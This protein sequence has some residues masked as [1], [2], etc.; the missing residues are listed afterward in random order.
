MKSLRHEAPGYE[1]ARDRLA[2]SGDPVAVGALADHVKHL[3]KIV[4][5]RALGEGVAGGQPLA[6]AS[7]GSVTGID[8]KTP[9]KALA[10]GE[11]GL[12]VKTDHLGL[13]AFYE[14]G[15][16]VALPDWAAAHPPS[17][18]RVIRP[19]H[20][21]DETRLSSAL[22][23][24]VEIDTGLRVEQDDQTGHAVL[25]AQGP[26]HFRRALAK[27]DG[28]FGIEVAEGQ[29][30]TAFRETIRGPA[31]CHHRHR[32]QSGGAG[33][34]A[35]VQIEV[36]LFWFRLGELLWA[37]VDRRRDNAHDALV[38]DAGVGQ[39]R[40]ARYDSSIIVK[41]MGDDATA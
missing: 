37:H 22:E 24:M 35:D 2:V 7:V 29:V 26:Q 20:D 14:A 4:L 5:V 34:F 36:A 40:A 25:C 32:K 8:A 38:Q 18:R 13:G 15:G 19:V 11:I 27:L 16:A 39:Q 10:P 31:A 6:G 12:T 28:A 30:P 33:Q 1:V 17:Y 41:R 21:R 23:R 3:G 9:V